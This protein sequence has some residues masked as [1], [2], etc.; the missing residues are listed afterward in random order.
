[1]TPKPAYDR[2]TVALRVEVPEP[3]P[4]NP[5]PSAW[6]WHALEDVPPGCEYIYSE[7]DLWRALLVY[8]A[9][10]STCLKPTAH[11][12][13]RIIARGLITG[14][15]LAEYVWQWDPFIGRYVPPTEPLIVWPQVHELPPEVVKG[16][17]ATHQALG[18]THED[19]LGH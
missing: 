19:H 9:A 3:K 4:N 6:R 17:L 14:R 12:R 5:D 18:S 7:R 15:F 2:P 13:F 16:A 8:G 1:M 10:A 11:P